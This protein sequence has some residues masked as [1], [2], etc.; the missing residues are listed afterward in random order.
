MR[1]KSHRPSGGPYVPT[2]S[3]KRTGSSCCLHYGSEVAGVEAG[4]A[5]Q[6]AVDVGLG[7]QLR[8]V[9]GLDRAAVE[10]ADRVSRAPAYAKGVADEGA[11][12]L[13]LLGRRGAA[14]ADRPDRLV[15]DHGARDRAAIDAGQVRLKLLLEHCIGLPGIACIL[16][17]ADAEDWL[18]AGG[19]RR[20]NLA[21]QRLVGLA[22][23][24]A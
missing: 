10:D 4:A 21:R 8:R 12:L 5:D 13:R 2:G 14:G 16:A 23:E 22:E 7:H 3:K 17:L 15:G 24:L 18:Q 11:G 20:R 9:V 19:Q 1:E 6:R